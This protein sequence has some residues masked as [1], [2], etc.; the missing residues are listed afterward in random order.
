MGTI[1]LGLHGLVLLTAHEALPTWGTSRCFFLDV[2]MK[3]GCFFLFVAT[4]KESR[5][6][7]LFTLQ[8][9]RERWNFDALMNLNYSL[10]RCFNKGLE[11][12]L[13]HSW[14]LT[15]VPRVV[16]ILSTEDDQI[17]ATW[18]LCL[19][20]WLWGGKSAIFRRSLHDSCGNVGQNKA[21]LAIVGTPYVW[22]SHHF[23]QGRC[24]SITRTAYISTWWC[25]VWFRL[26][27]SDSW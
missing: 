25:D 12:P 6:D 11:L 20:T 18:P 3:Q 13:S 16:R 10:A 17:Y 19:G 27:T 5:G 2:L 15:Q 4:N 8:E 1:V 7:N 22:T 26:C 14:L 23:S 21:S 24:V 9:I